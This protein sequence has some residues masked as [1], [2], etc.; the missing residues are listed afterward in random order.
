MATTTF[1]HPEYKVPITL[2]ASLTQDQVLQFQPFQSW[3]Q[4]LHH[5]LTTQSSPSHP[6]HTNPYALRSITIQSHDLFGP[7]RI[8]FLKLTC[9]V[10]T[11]TS[12]SEWLPGAVFLR[13]PSVAMLVILSPF[14]DP[15]ERHVLLTVQPRIA[16][17]SL[18]FVEL[19]AGMVDDATHTFAGTAAKEIK[20]ELGME[21]DVGGLVCLTDLAAEEN[22]EEGL[23]RGMYPSPGAC[24]EYIGLYAY[25]RSVPREELAGWTGRLTGLREEGERITLRLVRM[26]E[27]W[28]VAGRDGKTLAAVALW[29]GLK[30]EGRV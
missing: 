21:I 4:T 5:S 25:E 3:L 18:A 10:T 22:G 12:P 11:A 30:R 7:T 24:D 9:S 14:D 13:G 16:A 6:F 8:G 20:E 28:K 27:V 23:P 26:E 2:P 15:S 1:D 19:P 17:G 29:E